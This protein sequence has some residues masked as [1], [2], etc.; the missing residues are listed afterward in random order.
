[1][2]RYAGLSIFLVYLAVWEH[3]FAELP[4]EPVEL[5]EDNI[6]IVQLSYDQLLLE[7]SLFVYQTPE[8]T[9]I[10]VQGLIDSL[11]FP[12]TLNL[13]S[14]SLDGWFISEDRNFSLDINQKSVFLKG[15]RQT[16]PKDFQ[17]ALDGFDLYINLKSI[18]R[19]FD[20]SLLLDVSQLELKLS[21]SS[22]LPIVTQKLR[23]QKRAKLKPQ[24]K[25]QTA[26][27]YLPNEYD[28]LGSPSFDIEFSHSAERFE[29]YNDLTGRYEADISQYSSATVQGVMDI[30]KHSLQ[31][32]YVNQ[33]GAQDLRLTFS[34]AASGPEQRLFLGIDQYKFGDVNSHSSALLSGSVSGSGVHLKRGSNALQ[35]QS[36]D[37]LLEGDAPPGWEVELYRNGALIDF[38]STSS[39]GQYRFDK[40][41]TYLG[42]NI[43][44]IRIYGPQGQYR[45]EQK[46]ITVGDQMLAKGLWDF[47]LYALNRNQ[48]LLSL[49]EEELDESSS[50]FMSEFNAG[51]NDYLTIQGALSRF[52]PIDNEIEHLYTSLGFFASLGGGFGQLKYVSDQQ[53][54]HAWSLAYKTRLL[55][56]NINF[57]LEKYTDFISDKNP[58]GKLELDST[59]RING[60]W[61]DIWSQDISYDLELQHAQYANAQE[62]W[63]LSKRLSTRIG[64]TQI[65][66]LIN[67]SH[68]NIDDVEDSLITTLSATRRWHS[69][70]L[71]TE[72]NYKILPKGVLDSIQSSANY[73]ASKRVSYQASLGYILSEEDT[74]S[75][76]NMIS[77]RLDKYSFSLSAGFDTQDHQSIGLSISSALAYDK[78]HNSLYLSSESVAS[79]AS[80]LAHTYLD[81]NNNGRFDEQ[82]SPLPNIHFKGK[83]SWRNSATNEEGYV[84]L[85]GVPDLQMQTISINSRKIE[86]PFLKPQKEHFTLYSHSGKL[87]EISIGFQ[88]AMELEGEVL[89]ENNGK[90]IPKAGIPVS[91]FTLDD[92]LIQQTR[93]EYDGVYIFENVLP[94]SYLLKIDPDYLQSKNLSVTPTIE[95]K[96]SGDEGIIYLPPTHLKQKNKLL[97]FN[98]LTTQAT[99]T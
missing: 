61:A 89:L 84:S 75:F 53:S 86:D 19:W 21:S 9:F 76:D 93:T 3:A 6:L 46:K 58:D 27:D 11:D 26:H 33:D 22:P 59:L 8:N 36:S 48:R 69:W 64:Q 4:P 45:S 31:T 13:D 29:K 66:N 24:A 49:E 74:Y 78:P 57:D 62:Q 98:M 52:T 90:L 38:T 97:L 71:K 73:Q 79:S 81:H 95:L 42:E 15:E 23:A 88:T 12:L 7:E 65:A 1:M 43:F 85:W 54:G 32:S 72:A 94:G 92:S 87:N 80:V 35:E 39:N 91:L 47:Q 25:A 96:T 30:L 20:L 5:A 70:R 34:K 67:Y 68:N 55:N 83:N 99:I 77:W 2:P 17:Y 82:D 16:W 60:L 63:Q 40:I 50:F 41:S 28:W 10:P 51:L 44:D 14:L 56:T 37:L 18:E